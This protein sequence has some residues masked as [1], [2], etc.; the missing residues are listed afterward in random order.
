[1]GPRSDIQ[2]LRGVAVLAV[3]A[4]HAFPQWFPYGYLGVD[5]FFLISGFLMTKMIATGMDA[6]RFTFGG[7]YLRRAR[8]LLPAA[9]STLAVSTLL[10][11]VALDRAQ[12]ASFRA[13]L[14]GA[15]TFTANITALVQGSTAT[16][17]YP[18]RHIWSLS[19]EEQFYFIYPLL[20][21][22]V[23]P[24]RGR[25]A[26]LLGIAGVSFV[27]WLAAGDRT[28]AFYLL[29]F[30][31][32]ELLFGGVLYAAGFTKPTRLRFAPLQLIG[33]WSY[34]LYLI[35]WPLIS[36]AAL[37]FGWPLPPLTALAIC[38][39]SV[40]L[41]ALQYHYVE[42]PWRL[43]RQAVAFPAVERPA[44]GRAHLPSVDR[45]G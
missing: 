31:A 18:L 42:Q 44:A 8:R 34:S 32:W 20:L 21:F 38:F 27:A 15:L 6:A 24:T 4:C 36:F 30:R 7:F 28:A 25:V 13:D 3:L 19:L 5:L 41:A 9:F 40:A 1:V 33:D 45:T 23:I 11:W 16:G 39:L 10:A 35:H 43:P 12:W 29:P 14:L 17:V 26:W 37:V 2:V 22:W